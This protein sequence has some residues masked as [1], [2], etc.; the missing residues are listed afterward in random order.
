MIEIG[1]FSLLLALFVS[2]YAAVVSAYGA[3]A[4]KE[5]L[6]LSG[7]QAVY[8]VGAL[9]TISSLALAYAFLTHEFQ[10]EYVASY[11]SRSLP[12]FYALSAFWAGQK[13]SLLLW[14]WLL[15][16]FAIITIF[17]NRR[18]NQELIPYVISLMMGVNLFFLILLTFVCN[19]FERLPFSPPDGQ[20]LNP[21]L[22]NP[23][24]IFHP[25][26]LFV[27]YVGF[28]VPFAFAIAALITGQLGEAWIRTTRKWSLFSWF[29]LG[30]GVL[31]GAQWAYVELG[32]GGYWAWDPVENASLMPWLT[33]TAFLHSVM[34]QE[35]RGMLKVWNMVLIILTF[36]L[37]IF[38]T[39]LTRSGIISSVHSFGESTV[40]PFLLG[41]LVLFLL[42]SIAYLI[43]R[44]PSLK[45]ENQL[46]SLLSRES[47]FL[48]NNL[49]L[50]GAAFS[51]F[52][53]TIFPV[54]S[55]AVKGV[56]IT[57]GPPFFNQ[58][59]VP[60]GLALLLITGVCPLISWR[61]A[62][63]KNFRKNFLLPSSISLLVAVVLFIIGIRH[64]YAWLSFV[65]CLFV[66][67][68]IVIEFYRGTKARRE[69]TGK[70]YL[71]S[72]INLIAKNRR[73]YG[74]YLIHLSMVLI[75]FGITGSSAYQQEKEATLK[76]GESLRIKDFT[77]R[78]DRLE[79]SA[80]MHKITVGA[81]LT[82]S[83]NGKEL[84]RLRPERRYYR[85]QEQPTTEVA[86][87]SN[88]KEDLYAILVG[89]DTDGSA[90]FKVFVNPLVAWIWAGGLGLCLGIAI[91]LWP[92]R[93]IWRRS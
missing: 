78:Y 60:I 61:R 87:W 43:Y 64:T 17:Q 54:I 90:T 7:K 93:Q 37:C 49:I 46:D 75:F 62:S 4:E 25:P 70:G 91:I 15:A 2:A 89:Y 77:V 68:T 9:L 48:F 41:F 82:V 40:G 24:M 81:E 52:W 74:G 50:V 30:I 38:G 13:G 36:S 67:I 28:T 31:L 12:A 53:G 51:V 84:I 5:R 83:N 11:S 66:F 42:F 47:T 57:M 16:T 18:Q 20:G 58:V 72:F 80:D 85:A 56:K 88:P 3:I 55:E 32:W 8:A 23:G 69:L 34:I 86:I 39:F 14:S 73:R 21:L 44:L 22:Q 63:A 29:F 33:G 79:E 10:V 26:T 76:K 45:S 19:P 1:N 6:I 92:E 27:G 59:N 35:R 71:S 65:L